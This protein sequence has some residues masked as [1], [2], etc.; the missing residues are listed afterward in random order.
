M[1]QK[2]QFFPSPKRRTTRENLADPHA[3][4]EFLSVEAL[5]QA[6]LSSGKPLGLEAH[7]LYFPPETRQS[8]VS[9]RFT[10]QNEQ[11]AVMPIVLADR[12][13]PI[14]IEV[15]RVSAENW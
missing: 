6:E 7:V 14:L 4:V 9:N 1:Q 2:R 13:G 10:G 11:I 15:W 8:T 12:T 5:H 3:A